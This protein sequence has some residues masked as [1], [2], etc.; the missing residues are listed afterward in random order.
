[1]SIKSFFDNYGTAKGR[2]DIANLHTENSMSVGMGSRRL[3][4]KSA[5]FSFDLLK[6]ETKLGLEGKNYGVLNKLSGSIGHFQGGFSKDLSKRIPRWNIKGEADLFRF[7]EELSAKVAGKEYSIVDATLKGYG[8]SFEAGTGKFGLPF[9]KAE[10]HELGL[11]INAGFGDIKGGVGFGDSKVSGKVDPLDATFSVP[12]GELGYNPISP[13]DG[14]L[15]WEDSIGKKVSADIPGIGSGEFDFASKNLSGEVSLGQITDNSDYLNFIKG[16]NRKESGVADDFFARDANRHFLIKDAEKQLKDNDKIYSRYKDKNG[17]FGSRRKNTALDKTYGSI[18]RLDNAIAQT[19]AEKAIVDERLKKLDPNNDEA[20]WLTERSQ[21][22]GNDINTMSELC[23]KLQNDKN[24]LNA[25]LNNPDYARIVADKPADEL[26]GDAKEQSKKLDDLYQEKGFGKHLTDPAVDLQFTKN[27][28][29]NRCNKCD[30]AINDNNYIIDLNNRERDDYLKT[31]GLSLKEA[32][33]RKDPTI[34]NSLSE[35]ERL[36]NN[37]KELRSQKG[38]FQKAYNEADREFGVPNDYGSYAS[39][40]RKLQSDKIDVDNAMAAN[41]DDIINYSNRN[42][43][44]KDSDGNYQFDKDA[45]PNFQD[46]L[47]KKDSLEK[48][49]Q[50]ID[51]KLAVSKKDLAVREDD[52][53]AG[54][55]ITED[56][57]DARLDEI[58]DRSLFKASAQNTSVT[59]E[60]KKAE[61]KLSMPT[62]SVDGFPEQESPNKMPAA[63]NQQ[64]DENGNDLSGSDLSKCGP[65]N[66]YG[67]IPPEK[68]GS[69]KGIMNSTNFDPNQA[70]GKVHNSPPVA[71]QRNAGESTGTETKAADQ[72]PEKSQGDEQYQQGTG[73]AEAD[74][75]AQ[76]TGASKKTEELKVPQEPEQ[77]PVQQANQGTDPSKPEAAKTEPVKE[78]APADKT[79]TQPVQKAEPKAEGNTN[80][81][82]SKTQETPKDESSQKSNYTGMGM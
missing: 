80:T 24:I 57:G 60:G 39:Y 27:E 35:E 73:Q 43:I 44:T 2:V 11:D 45:H 79:N 30:E 54:F 48:D 68:S 77:K 19:K 20:K 12:S 18:D 38:E 9:F 64:T 40:D 75:Q 51:D 71:P 82:D 76:G 67:Y 65:S 63:F 62:T 32:I 36:R 49:S 55:T 72:T 59:R 15:E 25:N 17:W 56:D 14:K 23:N 61:A 4:K 47:N 31:N 74:K 21:K 66:D 41:N 34:L 10:A 3:N 22:L 37:N 69:E 81:E 33:D 6:G 28:L 42:G 16:N 53:K 46:L 78:Q 70:N 5:S 58:K 50:E 13:D 8:G 29:K 1:M 26:I 52:K 7:R